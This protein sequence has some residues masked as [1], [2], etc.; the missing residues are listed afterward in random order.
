MA[1]NTWDLKKFEDLKFLYDEE[2]VL[3]EQISQEVKDNKKIL[4]DRFRYI[5]KLVS[6][7][8]GEECQSNEIDMDLESLCWYMFDNVKDVPF[9]LDF[10]HQFPETDIR[11]FPFILF[12]EGTDK[13]I[14]EWCHA[15]M[16]LRNDNKRMR[17]TI[18][19]KLTKEEIEF[20]GLNCE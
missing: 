1:K 11:N 5:V 12:R 10:Y 20:L 13:E 9:G 17:E 4:K 16:D 15:E 2:K 7:T 19:S 14:V 18:K 6:K 8:I 3:A